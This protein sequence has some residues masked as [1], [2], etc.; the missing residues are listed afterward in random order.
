MYASPFKHKSTW[1]V[2]FSC[3]I[4]NDM[5]DFEVAASTLLTICEEING[6]RVRSKIV[7]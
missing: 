6:K 1:W 2:R 5:R 7:N 4:Y 3:Q